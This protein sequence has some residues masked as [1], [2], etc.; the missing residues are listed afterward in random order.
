MT[1]PRSNKGTH[2]FSF[3]RLIGL[4]VSIVPDAPHEPWRPKIHYKMHEGES[5]DR[6]KKAAMGKVEPRRSTPLQRRAWYPV[7]LGLDELWPS[8]SWASGA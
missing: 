7:P 2:G 6:L 8:R 5:L 4:G 1:V 3:T